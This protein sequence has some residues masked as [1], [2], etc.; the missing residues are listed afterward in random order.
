MTDPLDV[1]PAEPFAARLGSGTDATFVFG[2]SREAALGHREVVLRIF[3]WADP[4]QPPAGLEPVVV[5]ADPTPQSQPRVVV[6]P[7]NGKLVVVWTAGSP[8]QRNV[9]HRVFGPLGAPLS[10]QAIANDSLVG[11]QT[12]PAVTL[13]PATGDVAIAW[14]SELPSSAT[15]QKVSAKIF[16]ALLQ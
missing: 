6:N 4:Q 14:T 15:P 10:A 12:S 3:A 16:P 13:D 5:S 9:L 8:P 7:D 1:A 2:Y 11:D